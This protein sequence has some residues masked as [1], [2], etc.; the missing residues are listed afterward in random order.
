VA[1]FLEAIGRETDGLLVG[2]RGKRISGGRP[3]GIVAEG[4]Y[5]LGAAV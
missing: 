1:A 5:G 2:C 4:D 3:G